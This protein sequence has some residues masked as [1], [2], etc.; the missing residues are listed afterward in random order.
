TDHVKRTFDYEPFVREYLSRLRQ[1]AL[2][3]PLLDRDEEGRKVK[4]TKTKA[5]EGAK[6]KG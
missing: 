5:K 3:N 6:E 2:L 4:K 1:E